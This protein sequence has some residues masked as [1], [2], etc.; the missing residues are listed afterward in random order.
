MCRTNGQRQR[1]RPR[2]TRLYA[3]VGAAAVIVGLGNMALERS[4]L[5]RPALVAIMLLA[6]VVILR[7][8][9]ANA[10]ALDLDGWCDCAASAVIVRRV[11]V[12]APSTARAAAPRALNASRGTAR[13][14]PRRYAGRAARP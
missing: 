12:E 10:A 8:V 14:S 11:A 3:L 7:W 5:R 1:M 13:R 4:G 2:W 9:A 6:G